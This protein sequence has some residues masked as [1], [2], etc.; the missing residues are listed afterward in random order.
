MELV[1]FVREELAAAAD[2]AKAPAMQAYMK[3]EM[4]FLGV[5]KAGR[6][7]VLRAAR[8]RFAPVDR[9]QWRAQV[10]ALW[11]LPHREEKYLALAWAR[12]YKTFAVAD[13]LPF[14]EGLI[15]EGAWWDFVDEIAS[16]LVGEAW[17]RQRER[18]GPVM[19]RW[20]TDEDVWIRR[21]AILGQLRHKEKTDTDRLLGYCEARAH[22]QS[23]WIRKA[24]GWSLRQHA[25]TD[26]D[27][28]VAFLERMGDRL[29]GLSR[30]EAGKHLP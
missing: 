15:R 26:P 5:Q 17:L 19:D 13:E 9:D 16:H 3:T 10:A 30:R 21:T 11:A 28:V 1:E 27:L 8:K 14:L 12:A 25:R 2:P 29:S 18:V 7:P 4:P 24:I 23:F 22:E 6:A 20:I